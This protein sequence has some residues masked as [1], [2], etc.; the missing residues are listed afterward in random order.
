MVFIMI[1]GNMPPA[2]VFA[3][4]AVQVAPM[5]LQ[6]TSISIRQDLLMLTVGLGYLAY[7]VY[8][9]RA[10]LQE[11]GVSGFVTYLM[12]SFLSPARGTAVQDEPMHQENNE[13]YSRM[14]KTISRLPTEEFKAPS[15][16]SV[17]DLKERLAVRGIPHGKVIE[18]EEFV[19]LLQDFRGGPAA[20]CCICCE[21]YVAGD[22]LRILS[23]C[24][25]DFHLE[26]MD[27]WALTLANSTRTPSCPL[28]NQE[29]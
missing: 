4:I 18:K 7:T 26:C 20:S 5:L 11:R 9:K 22:V 10:V 1:N 23:T 17:H 19:R 14:L 29:L 16:C 24:K 15:E 12:S 27:K 28:C 6:G 25:H 3:M 13:Q 21:D 8:T 2:V